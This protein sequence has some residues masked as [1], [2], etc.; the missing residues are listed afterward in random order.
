MIGAIILGIVAGFLGRLLL[1]GR[2]PMGFFATILL[3]LAGSLV[4]FFVFTELL[5]IGDN[6]MFD[7][8]GLSARHRRDAAAARLPPV[9]RLAPRAGDAALALPST[10]GA[11]CERSHGAPRQDGRILGAMRWEPGSDSTNAIVLR[12]VV[13]RARSASVPGRLGA[14]VA[15]LLEA[16]ETGQGWEEQQAFDALTAAHRAAI[17]AGGN[18]SWCL[19]RFPAER[20][21]R[22]LGRE[23]S[24]SARHLEDAYEALLDARRLRAP[25]SALVRRAR[26]RTA[27]ADRDEAA[28]HYAVTA[29][30][31]SA[32][33]ERFGDLL[34]ELDA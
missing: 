13:G 30:A 16:G 29:M 2:D 3:G 24:I 33:V 25:W 28:R 23:V 8:G 10:R 12:Q 34:D 9:R 14:A 4:G 5:G 18:L 20:D 19:D 7:L 1:P 6:E 27:S 26:G 21:V 31:F 32:R 11:L 17:A 22:L 15:T